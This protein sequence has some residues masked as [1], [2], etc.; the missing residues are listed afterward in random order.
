MPGA[1]RR[2]TADEGPFV[3]TPSAAVKG[4]DLPAAVFRC[5]GRNYQRRCAVYG[6]NSSRLARGVLLLTATIVLGL[7]GG[8]HFLHSTAARAAGEANLSSQPVNVV[9]NEVMP[10]P[11]SGEAAWVELYVEAF[12]VYLPIVFKSGG[13]LQSVSPSGL[14]AAASGIDLSGWQVSNESGDVY[15]LPAALTDVPANTYVL[16]YFD[17]LG[18]GSDDYDPSDGLITL[19]TP[20]GLGDVFPDEA[21]QVALYQPGTLSAQTIVDFLV[22]GGFDA[23]AGSN[24]VAAGVWPRGQ[25]ATF[26]NGFGDI[27]LEDI[28]E[29]GESLGRF[30]GSSGMGAG[31]WSNYPPADTTPGAANPVQPVLF[32][33][34]ENGASVDASEFSL[35]WRTAAGADSYRFQLDDDSDFTSPLVD[36]VVEHPYYQPSANL[37]K[38]GAPLLPAGTYYWR[39]APLRSSLMAAWSSIFQFETLTPVGGTEKVLDIARVRQNKDSYLL[40]LDGAPEGDPT[41]N[42][43]EDAWDSPA[44]CT[45]PPCVDD[46]KYM[47]GNMYCVRASIRM[48]ASWYNGGQMLSMDRISYHILEEWSGNTRPGS[49]DGIPDNDLGYNRGMYFPDEED[50]GISWAL[51]T[52]IHG[53]EAKPTFAEIRAWIDADRPVMFRRPG[54]MMVI[55]GYR[56]DADGVEF[57]HVLDPDQPPDFERWQEYDTQTIEGYWPGPASGTG[58]T[59]EASVW[60][61]SDGDGIMDFDEVV[62]FNLDPFSPDTDGDWVQDKQDMRAYVFDALGNYDKRDADFDGDS[63]RKEADPDN[64]GDGSPDGCE[65]FTYNGIYEPPLGESNNFD[66]DE[67]RACVPQFEILYPL[68]VAPV[69]AGAPAAPHKILVQ[70]SAAVPAGWTLSLTPA[71]FSVRIGTE[72]ASVLAVYP[73]AD[74]YFLVVS[75]PV[76]GSAAYY[77]LQVALNGAGTDSEENAVYYLESPPQDEVIVLDRSGSMASDGKMEAAQNAGSAFVDFLDDGDA[78]GVTSFAD[79]AST[80]YPLTTITSG[81]TERDDAIAAIDGLTAGGST[82]LGQGVQQGYGLLTASGDPA[83][84]WSLVLLSDGWENVPPYWEDVEGSITDAVVHTVALGDGADTAL[85]QSIAGSK[86]GTYFFVD[87][88]P[89][90]APNIAA[91][92][93]GMPPLDIPTQLP[94]RL[95]DAYVSIG[96]L[97]HGMQRLAE[98]TGWAQEQQTVTFAVDIGA[99]IPEAVFTVNWDSRGGFIKI[100]LTDPSGQA[101]TPDAEYRDDTHHQVRVRSPQSGEWTVALQILKPA[102]EY[103]FMLSAQSETTLMA[104]VGGTPEERVPWDDVPIYGI[105]SDYKPIGGSQASVYA[106]VAGP[107]L[108]RMD[109][110][111]T[112]QL[113]DDGAHGDG[114]ADDGVFAGMIPAPASPGGFTVKLVAWGTNNSGETFTRYAHADFNVRPRLAYLWDD[115][116]DTAVEYKAL[117]EDDGWAVDLLPLEDVPGTNFSRYSLIVVGPDTGLYYTFDDP[118]ASAAL[119]QWNTPILGLGSGGAAL[120]SDFDLSIGYGHTWFSSNNEVYAVTPASDFWHEP[121]EVDVDPKTNLAALYP[122]TVTELGVYIPEEIPGV[123]PIAREKRN[124]THYPVVLE[125]RNGREYILWGYNLGPDGMTDD[126]RKLLLN[127]SAY[128]GR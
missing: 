76:Q 86:H 34:P 123:T 99:G 79:S 82:A 77:N 28:L 8:S 126:G 20:A 36:V 26:E 41:T 128:L 27:S 16:I 118:D 105:L 51:N 45:E 115:D 10:K 33:T 9:L 63:A 74:T 97:T 90:S 94:N 44:P 38:P 88:D 17:G 71:D 25:A 124:E 68:K 101:V 78:I 70:V 56:V 3:V 108:P 104:A 31:V 92:T 29:K 11:A 95:A 96:E 58:R 109:S 87:V 73:S 112:I 110:I 64:D 59:D 18:A 14:Q 116:A 89:P 85:L 24:A 83:H 35:A 93:A 119:A 91:V 107:G 4:E 32:V 1:V 43:P 54:H 50:E 122:G 55:N 84:D 113:F 60:T 100:G 121:F 72:T 48:M 5:C 2:Q 22:W 102:T 21:G 81:G 125:T 103:H 57:I 19:H 80:D 61:D 15:T 111:A 120:F 23:S 106:L 66:A 52:T 30:P 39:V 62:R 49:N 7:L 37:Q 117:L 127:L 65:D 47:H 46:T 13:S 67:T 40:G 53:P 12:R 69:N 114:G 75:P 98:N 6:M 42:T